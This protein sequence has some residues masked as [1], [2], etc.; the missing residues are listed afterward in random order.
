[1]SATTVRRVVDDQALRVLVW[2]SATG[3]IEEAAS[4]EVNPGLL[5]K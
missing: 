4:I 2:W 3:E 1:L 5:W